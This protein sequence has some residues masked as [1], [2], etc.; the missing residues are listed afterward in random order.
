MAMGSESENGHSGS[1]HDADP[2]RAGDH[3]TLSFDCCD[4]FLN[5]TEA[6]LN[7]RMDL[8]LKIHLFAAP[9]YALDSSLA[10]N[11][12]RNDVHGIRL[13]KPPFEKWRLYAKN[14]SFLI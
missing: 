3:E 4:H 14:E 10:T 7:S 9:I 2:C 6:R 11:G 1:S 12:L 5:R 13:I 8:A